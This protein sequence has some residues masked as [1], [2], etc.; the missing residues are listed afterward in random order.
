MT[1]L[2]LRHSYFGKTTS[3]VVFMR[4]IAAIKIFYSQ[5]TVTAVPMWWNG[6]KC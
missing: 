6:E 3:D 4:I 2:R 5:A 1:G